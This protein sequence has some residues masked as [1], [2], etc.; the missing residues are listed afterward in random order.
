MIGYNYKDEPMILCMIEVAVS[1]IYYSA[2]VRIN[3]ALK[4]DLSHYIAFLFG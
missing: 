1:F 2:Q 3:N 4:I